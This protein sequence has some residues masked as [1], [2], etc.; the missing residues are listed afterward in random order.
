[1]LVRFRAGLHRKEQAAFDAEPGRVFLQMRPESDRLVRIVLPE[2]RRTAA[3]GAP[4]LQA[5]AEGAPLDH[6][7]LGIRNLEKAG[8]PGENTGLVGTRFQR[9]RHRGERPFGHRVSFIGRFSGR[10]GASPNSNQ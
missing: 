6:V 2:H 10:R 1:M 8:V 9:A 7:A 4:G 3:L 5:G